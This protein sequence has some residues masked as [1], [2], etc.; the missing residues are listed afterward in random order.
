MLEI[1]YSKDLEGDLYLTSVNGDEEYE[2]NDASLWISVEENLQ[3]IETDRL[4]DYADSRGDFE[5]SQMKEE[6]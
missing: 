4:R 5:Y 2:I 6:I 1:E 3:E